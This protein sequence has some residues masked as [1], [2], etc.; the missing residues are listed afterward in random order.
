[1]GK[2]SIIFLP[3]M[4]VHEKAYSSF[5]IST[6]KSLKM[7]TGTLRR[8]KIVVVGAGPVGTLAAL[9]AAGRGDD[10]EVYEYREGKTASNL[11]TCLAL[12]Y[13]APSKYK[14][15]GLLWVFK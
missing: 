8:Q 14:K 1:M 5:N 10:V 7:S 15:D 12:L 4:D 11:C 13:T 2:A 9:Y 6:N 3:P